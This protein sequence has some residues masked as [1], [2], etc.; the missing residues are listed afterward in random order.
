MNYGA[1]TGLDLKS[2]IAYAMDKV[3][4]EIRNNENIMKRICQNKSSDC[5]K[6]I[7]DDSYRFWN[8]IYEID[9]KRPCQNDKNCRTDLGETC[10]P[11]ND[12][13]KYCGYSTQN[14][15]SGK[16]HINDEKLCTENSKIPIKC[17]NDKCDN[18]ENAVYTEWRE[19]S[20]LQKPIKDLK[21][22]CI[23]G[24]FLL[25]EYA[26]DPKYRE[27]N[28]NM[29]N[30]KDFE[31][32]YDDKVGKIYMTKEYCSK[33]NTKYSSGNCGVLSGTDSSGNP[34]YDKKE[35]LCQG[36]GVCKQNQDDSYACDAEERTCQTNDKSKCLDT[37]KCSTELCKG[38]DCPTSGYCINEYANCYSDTGKKIGELLLGKT[39]FNWFA[40]EKVRERCLNKEEFENKPIDNLFTLFNSF[41]DVCSKFADINYIKSKKLIYSNFAGEGIHLYKIEWNKKAISKFNCPKIE[42][43]FI[44][45]EIEKIYN[46]IIKNKNNGRYIEFSKKDIINNN[47]KRI[48]LISNIGTLFNCEKL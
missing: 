10:I 16:F 8:H 32:K 39:L 34:I 3:N 6:F 45:Q 41:P 30:T 24:N 18:I 37:E 19:N 15:V 36:K 4:Q 48:Y 1:P 22:K 28:L 17:E 26:E 33:Y 31:L 12:N 29:E 9:E 20:E 47:I 27:I 25:K 5:Y 21:G 11:N 38:N 2:A 14:I 13:K 44:A 40:S 23:Y 46:H 42:V 35:E 7:P 43:G